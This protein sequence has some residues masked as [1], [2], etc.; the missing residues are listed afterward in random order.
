M[1][2]VGCLFEA[3]KLE[4]MLLPPQLPPKPHLRIFF[5]FFGFGAAAC[6]AARL[7]AWGRAR[8]WTARA[9]SFSTLVCKQHRNETG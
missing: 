4:A 2:S 5:F 6:A 7:P 3:T 8:W 9:Y 1:I